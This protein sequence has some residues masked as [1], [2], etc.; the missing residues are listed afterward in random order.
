MLGLWG[1]R[2][3]LI[4][5]GSLAGLPAEFRGPLAGPVAVFK[6]LALEAVLLV[7]AYPAVQVAAV[8]AVAAPL[9]ALVAVRP[10]VAAPLA[11]VAVPLVVGRT[12]RMEMEEDSRRVHP[13]SADRGVVRGARLRPRLRPRRLVAA[14]RRRRRPLRKMRCGGYFASSLRRCAA[15]LKL[16]GSGRSRRASASPLLKFSCARRWR[17]SRG[18]QLTKIVR[19]IGGK[20]SG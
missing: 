17:R 2:L 7:E 5:C 14:A 10:V 20:T 11:E 18:G 16:A 12:I 1:P 3:D 9:V 6:V 15:C 8:P 4:L 13:S 19:T